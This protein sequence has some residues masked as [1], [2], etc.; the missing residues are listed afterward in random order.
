LNVEFETAQCFGAACRICM[1]QQQIGAKP[2]K[3]AHAVRLGFE[4]RSIEVIGGD[5]SAPCRAERTLSQ[6]ERLLRLSSFA[7]LVP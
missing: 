4:D 2:D 7:Q 1:R 6:P 5:P 3:P